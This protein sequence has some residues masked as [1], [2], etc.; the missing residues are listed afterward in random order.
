[1]SAKSGHDLIELGPEAAQCAPS[2]L[3]SADINQEV[4]KTSGAPFY[5]AKRVSF[6]PVVK[7]W[8][9]FCHGWTIDCGDYRYSLWKKAGMP[10][11]PDRWQDVLDIGA[12]IRD[13]QGVQVGIGMSQELDTKMV[14]RSIMWSWDT[15]IQDEWANVVLDRTEENRE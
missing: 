6:N 15:Y 9:S 8:Y 3:V 14:A 13:K 2:L 11:G 4:T 10:Q 12:Q 5:V 1:M 7:T